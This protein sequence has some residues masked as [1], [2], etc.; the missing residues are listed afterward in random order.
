[1]AS[2]SVHTAVVALCRRYGPSATDEVIEQAVRH[3]ESALNR[4]VTEVY[5]ETVLGDLDRFKLAL[6]E[7]GNAVD[8]LSPQTVDLLYE[9]NHA[10]DRRL[11]EVMA[12]ASEPVRKPDPWPPASWPVPLDPVGAILDRYPSLSRVIESARERAPHHHRERRR[13]RKSKEGDERREYLV[14]A[15]GHAYHALTGEAPDGKVNSETGEPYGPFADFVRE[16]LDALDL[17]YS[18]EKLRYSVRTLVE[19][20]AAAFTDI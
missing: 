15:L 11:D 16:A 12:E 5:V 8:D 14:V 17:E 1:M 10:R 20:A 4:Y 7:L 3:L 9:A 13:G 18:G 2:A 19:D 6:S